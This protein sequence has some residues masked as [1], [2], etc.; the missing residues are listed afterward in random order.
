MNVICNMGFLY[1]AWM[2]CIGSI[3]ITGY[4]VNNKYIGKIDIL[5]WIGDLIGYI[6]NIVKTLFFI[7]KS[8]I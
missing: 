3:A 2:V 7:I 6:F 8:S 1:I 4:L 5:K